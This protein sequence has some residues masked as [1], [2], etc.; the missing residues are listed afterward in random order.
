[1]KKIL[2]STL[3]IATLS[4]VNVYAGGMDDIMQSKSSKQSTEKSTATTKGSKSSNKGKAALERE[5]LEQYASVN[6]DQLAKEIAA[7]QG[8]TLDTLATM[9]KVE[10]TAA[11]ASKLQSNYS[12]IYTSSEMKSSEVLSNISSLS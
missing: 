10:D 5:Q 3:A 8:E 2:L 9:M 11:F 7:G 12:K 1:M 6:S 4:I